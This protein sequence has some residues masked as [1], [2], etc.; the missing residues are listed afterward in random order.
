MK[1]LKKRSLLVNLLETK[2]STCDASKLLRATSLLQKSQLRAAD[3]KIISPVH[4]NFT[5]IVK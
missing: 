3:R 5:P 2:P 4:K 1:Q